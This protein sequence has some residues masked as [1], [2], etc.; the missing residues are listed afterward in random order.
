MIIIIRMSI[1]VVPV[2]FIKNKQNQISTIKKTQN[3]L[4]PIIKTQI[5]AIK[6]NPMITA[7]QITNAVTK[8]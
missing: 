3:A 6:V 7:I 4:I 2:I 1:S 8:S 5:L